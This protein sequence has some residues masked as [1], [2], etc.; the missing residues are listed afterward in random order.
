MAQVL[1]EVPD[2]LHLQDDSASYPLPLNSYVR[3]EVDAGT[4]EGVAAIP[5]G[6]LRENSQ[7]WVCDVEDQLA[8]RTVEVLWRQEE[9]LAVRDVFEQGEALIVSPLSDVLPGMALRPREEAANDAVSE[10]AR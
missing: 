7:V 5:R 10:L 8:I 4:L 3:A 1:I 2:P 9:V 6:A